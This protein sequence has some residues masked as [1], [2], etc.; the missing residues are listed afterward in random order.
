MVEAVYILEICFVRIFLLGGR[1][2]DSFF[3]IFYIHNPVSRKL[4][5]AVVFFDFLWTAVGNNF[6]AL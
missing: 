6:I 5:L 2:K 3:Q 4:M 1:F